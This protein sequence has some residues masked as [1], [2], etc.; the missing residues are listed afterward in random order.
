MQGILTQPLEQKT[1]R[2]HV[3]HYTV[4]EYIIE[5]LMTWGVQRIYGVIGDANLHFLDALSHQDKITY[6]ACKHEAAAA[7]MAS[8]EAK[9]TGNLCVC[10]ATSGP[11][12]ANLMNGLG[13]AAMD[14]SGVMAITGQ[15]ETSKIGTTAKQYINQQRLMSG[16]T[17]YSELLTDAKALPEL[18]KRL[19][20]VTKT[21]GQLTHLSIPKD[22]Y[23]D[24]LQAQIMPYPSYLHQSIEPPKALIE[25]SA[26]WM[27]SAERPVLLMGRGAAS[28]ANQIRSLAERLG[29]AVITTMPARPLFPNDHVMY[30][31]GLGQ[32]GSEASTHLLQ[33]SD[34]I[35]ILGATWWP[36]EFV[37]T[38]AN[39]IQVDT[40][41]SNIGMNPPVRLGIVGDLAVVI[42][43]WITLL[44]RDQPSARV[45]WTERI[46]Q[47]KAQWHNTITG[48]IHQLHQEP[49]A[50]QRLV[51]LMAEAADEDAIIALDTGDHSVWFNRIFQAKSKQQILVS[52]RWRTLGF[53]LPAA[54]AAKL[55]QPHRQVMALVGDGGVIQTLMEFQTAVDYGLDITVIIVNNGCYAMEKNR[56]KIGGLNPLGSELNNPDF[57]RIVE[58]CG[59]LG[60]RA[61]N[62]ATFQ[63]ALQQAV[64]ANLPALIDVQVQAPIIPHTHL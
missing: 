38:N 1:N 57:A 5:Q 53:G 22:I 32:A 14:L 8:A 40:Q 17:E 39:I 36:E 34:L 61:H 44:P 60:L 18:L 62:A 63:Q 4:S 2:P 29:A 30:S 6:I 25:Q 13:D 51:H 43:E 11:G 7:M 47:E 3:S 12:I 41:A 48:E 58:A 23:L 35:L 52:G 21:S 54:I 28:S 9:L 37:P 15:V 45:Q 19:F 55:A 16:L 33:E 64:Q 24:T 20:V 46:Q 50:P 59:G 26:E 49:I 56:M 27:K 10:L 31:G 42:S